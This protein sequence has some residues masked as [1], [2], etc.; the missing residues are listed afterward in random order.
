[1][2]QLGT[3]ITVTFAGGYIAELLNIEE[4]GMS[5]AA[6]MTSHSLSTEHEF[7]PAALVDYGQLD[8]EIQMDPKLAPPI[9]QVAETCT[10][11]F[12]DGS[13][14]AREGFATEFRYNAPTGPTE[15]VIKATMSVK[16][17]GG[18]TVT[19]PV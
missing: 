4:S 14:W 11:N 15:D 3:G 6:V 17:S 8:C 19:P 12:T 7:I 18:L 5:R 2:P 1:M 13:T 10:V 16:F 9:D